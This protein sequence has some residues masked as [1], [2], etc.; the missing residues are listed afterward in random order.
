MDLINEVYDEINSSREGAQE[1]N[2]QSP[3]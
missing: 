1:Y 2:A 3:R